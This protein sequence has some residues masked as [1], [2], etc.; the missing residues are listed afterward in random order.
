MKICNGATK[1]RLTFSELLSGDVFTVV[2]EEATLD[3]LR[4][5]VGSSGAFYFANNNCTHNGALPPSTYVVRYPN[6]C[7]TLGEPE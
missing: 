3:N 4:M 6:A 5:R 7:I 2:G 1:K